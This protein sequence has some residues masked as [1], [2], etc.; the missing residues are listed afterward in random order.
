MSILVFNKVNKTLGL[1]RQN[2]LILLIYEVRQ[3]FPKVNSVEHW[4]L[5][6]VL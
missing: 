4:S 1:F 3:A 5:A 6:R 2:V